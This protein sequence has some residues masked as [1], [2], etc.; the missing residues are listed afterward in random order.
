[1]LLGPD[2]Q[3]P[4]QLV[5]NVAGFVRPAALFARGSV[6]LAQGFPEARCLIADGQLGRHPEAA[7]LEIEQRLASRPGAL[8][9]AVSDRQQLLA[10]V[11]VSADDDRDALLVMIHT[12]LETDPVGP[13]AEVAPGSR[14]SRRASSSVAY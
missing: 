10:A 11:F 6:G 2:L 4:G 14:F 5:Q 1:M 13:E 12:G 9:V 8:A 3:R 7:P